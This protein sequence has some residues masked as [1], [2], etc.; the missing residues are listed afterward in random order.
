MTICCVYLQATLGMILQHPAFLDKVLC[1]E[2]RLIGQE[3]T[4][5]QT[6]VGKTMCTYDFYE[7]RFL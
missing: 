4:D 5:Y 2:L 7:G 3:D 1:E 6:V